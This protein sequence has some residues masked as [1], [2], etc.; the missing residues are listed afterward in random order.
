MKNLKWIRYL[1]K[2]YDIVYSLNISRLKEEDYNYEKPYLY[3]WKNKE[4]SVTLEINNE[5]DEFIMLYKILV[6]LNNW[7]DLEVQHKYETFSLYDF[8]LNLISVNRSRNQNS[9][10]EN[11]LYFTEVTK[12]QNSDRLN[13]IPFVTYD[14]QDYINNKCK[15]VTLEYFFRYYTD[16]L[17]FVNAKHFELK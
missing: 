2:L 17:Y 14:H 16:R 1:N 8:L 13:V 12:N 9:N 5:T 11:F 6:E 4:E 3:I 7:K 15:F 10:H